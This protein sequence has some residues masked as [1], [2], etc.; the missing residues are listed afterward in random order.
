MSRFR[1]VHDHRDVFE[2]K[3]LCEVLELSRSSYYKWPAGR[4]E[5]PGSGPTGSW[6]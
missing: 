3:R 5:R 6:R 2:V 1:S 4:P